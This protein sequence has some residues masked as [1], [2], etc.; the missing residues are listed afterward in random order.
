MLPKENSKHGL[1]FSYSFLM[2]IDELVTKHLLG[3]KISKFS[4]K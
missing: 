4:E 1:F 3:F 2:P